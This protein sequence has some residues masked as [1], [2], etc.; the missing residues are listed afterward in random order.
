MKLRPITFAMLAIVASFG[1]ATRCTADAD[2]I[3]L[4]S[5]ELALGEMYACAGDY[6][7]LQAACQLKS[8]YFNVD[9]WLAL[10]QGCVLIKDTIL[11]KACDAAT[12]KLQILVTGDVSIY[13]YPKIADTEVHALASG[14][15]ML[16]GKDQTD[17]CEHALDKIRIGS[18]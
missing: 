8:K 14:C 2:R 18:Q 6:S 13:V 4:R 7:G 15:S 11:H 3:P 5:S 10:W 1:V 17:I 9:D 12:E 16:P